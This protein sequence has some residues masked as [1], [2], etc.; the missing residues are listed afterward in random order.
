M[1]LIEHFSKTT[2]F[3]LCSK[4]FDMSLVGHLYFLET[5]NVYGISKTLIP[6]RDAKFVGYFLCTLQTRL[7]SNSQFSSSHHPQTNGQTKVAN[8]SLGKFLKGLIGDSPS[9]ISLLH[10]QNLCIISQI[11]II[12]L[13]SHL[14]L[15]MAG[16]QSPNVTQFLSLLLI[17]LVLNVMN[18]RVKLKRFISKFA[19]R[20]RNIINNV[21]IMPINIT[22]GFSYP[23]GDLV[24]IH[25]RQVTFPNRRFNKIHRSINE[26]FRVFKKTMTMSKSSK[27]D[28]IITRHVK[29]M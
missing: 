14:I 26:P 25:L 8:N 5:L 20:L 6:D 18:C 3:I 28:K 19:C 1:V 17:T 7:G 22:S 2:H 11:T 21:L 12:W 13:R 24:S 23:E 27:L 9:G 16:T 4:K 10:L 15:C 29:W